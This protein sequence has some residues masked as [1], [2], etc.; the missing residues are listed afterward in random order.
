MPQP[1]DIFSEAAG[2]QINF[3][4]PSKV[5]MEAISHCRQPKA[6]EVFYITN[7]GQ[8]VLLTPMEETLPEPQEVFYQTENGELVF[9]TDVEEGL[10]LLAEGWT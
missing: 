8:L 6:Q 1:Q 4:H 9:L 7:K 2:G 3:M 10:W 5:E